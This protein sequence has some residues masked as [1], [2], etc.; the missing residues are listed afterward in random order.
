MTKAARQESAAAKAAALA[1]LDSGEFLDAAIAFLR[2]II[3][4]QMKENK[5]RPRKPQ[6][7]AMRA[8]DCATLAGLVRTLEKLDALDKTREV[9]GRKTKTKTDAELEDGF[10]RRLDK[11]LAAGNA[12]QSAGQPESGQG[13]GAS[14]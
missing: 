11:L 1:G 12:P 3:M 2:E 9:R 7:A 14:K 8:R 10:V 6:V 5:T 13:K 4:A